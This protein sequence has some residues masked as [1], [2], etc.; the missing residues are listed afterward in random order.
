MTQSASGFLFIWLLHAVVA[1]GI[2]V[3]L[4]GIVPP[5]NATESL[6]LSFSIALLHLFFVVWLV[7]VMKLTLRI[8]GVSKVSE[9]VAAFTFTFLLLTSQYRTLGRRLTV[10]VDTLS[11]YDD[12]SLTATMTHQQPAASGFD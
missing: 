5:W 3:T 9:E 12:M 1:M 6:T 4:N 8:A 11:S 7:S 10:I 2:G